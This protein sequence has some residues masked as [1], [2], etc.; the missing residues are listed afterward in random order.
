MKAKKLLALLLTGVMAAAVG[1]FAAAC[2]NGG[3]S[4]GGPAG[5]DEGGGGGT[6]GNYDYTLDETEY[7]LAGKGAGSLKQV[8]EWSATNTTLKLVRD[9][10][11]DHNVF[12]ITIDMYAHDEFKIVHDSD[13]DDNLVFDAIYPYEMLADGYSNG[14][15]Y[16]TGAVSKNEDGEVVFYEGGAYKG[17]ITL[18]SGHDGTYK[19]SL[20][21]YPDGEE[22]T[23]ITW[24]KVGE[25][26]ALS[27]MYVVGDFND[28][29]DNQKQ[30]NKS[31]M[32][33]TGDVWR[34]TLEVTE[35]HLKYNAEG[36]AG[37]DYT[38]IGVMN[39]V[40]DENGVKAVYTSEDYATAIH[41]QDEYNLVPAGKYTVTYNS[42][43]NSV[44]IRALTNDIYFIGSMNGWN[45]DMGEEWKLTEDPTTG[46]W[47]GYLT[48]TEKD[49]A[50]DKV[51]EKDV[52]R[53]YA[54]V[55]LYN[56]LG[57]DNWLAPSEGNLD[58]SGNIML[59]AGDYAFYYN[60]ETKE[61]KYEKL[62]YFVLGTFVDDD[63]HIQ[64]F[65][66]VKDLTPAMTE[67]DGK[68]V[69]TV[70]VTDVSEVVDGTS[71][72]KWLKEQGGATAI[73]AIKVVYGS[74]LL[75]AKDWY[76]IGD[77]GD[78]YFFHAEGEYSVTFDPATKAITVAEVVHEVTVT[79]NL[80]YTDAA[81]P[82]VETITQGTTVTE[83]TEPEREEYTFYG[84]YTE[85]NCENKFDFTKPVNA[86]TELYA[87]WVKT[88]DIPQGTKVTFNFNG[89]GT[90]DKD[91]DIDEYGLV[92]PEAAEWAG[93]Y[94]LGWYTAQN[95]GE[96]VNFN[97][98]VTENKTVYA[99]WRAI[100]THNYHILG[101]LKNYP[102]V[103]WQLENDKTPL[104]HS[105]SHPTEN[106]F[107]ISLRLIVGDK[108]KILG[109][110]TSW[111]D[112]KF[113]AWAIDSSCGNE[114]VYDEPGNDGGNIKV[115]VS[116]DYVLYAS[117]DTWKLTWTVEPFA[118][119]NDMYFV[120]G[121]D[122]TKM[123]AGTDA[124]TGYITVD[125]TKPLKLIDK[126]DGNKEYPVGDGNLP[127]GEY[128][129]KFNV[130][131]KTVQ[132]EKC[133]Y[134]IVGTLVIDDKAVSF[135]IAEGSPKLTGDGNVLT[136]DLT[137]TDI[138]QNA[139]YSWLAEDISKNKLTAGTI[140]A[141]KIGYGSVLGDVRDWYGNYTKNNVVDN[142]S[143]GDNLCFHT[144]G[145]YTVTFDTSTNT[146]TVT[147]KTA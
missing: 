54:T 58:G 64:N 102:T 57:K 124:W 45:T 31:H 108:F 3:G 40:E 35:E 80:N 95:N 78:N 130:E 89:N 97:E 145:E 63:D 10:E 129:V 17:N 1:T 4:G 73:F 106:M 69:A 79:F 86:N 101:E 117:A 62:G 47:S 38:M 74:V 92:A 39:N 18:E 53:D 104:S 142:G 114:L 77:N 132:Y 12:T 137:V 90:P 123:A 59:T 9:E 76:G 91:V 20:H 112:F 19:F 96:L 42:A 94:F 41:E 50:V 105:E 36:E 138:S 65:V 33:K 140:F 56:K 100:D 131:A 24:E 126:Y 60:P 116:G 29:G 134:Y 93:H 85:E 51:D 103:T 122:E 115:A 7:Y 75:G 46:I 55:K 15:S 52:Q 99:H 28:F 141:I 13:Y 107:T 44:S 136:V 81:E 30:F 70:N 84:W 144:A 88:S 8:P 121:E 83:P 48:I 67:S 16:A 128:F 71:N 2:N 82:Q 109:T 23:K 43:D 72:Y 139:G 14:D 37:T 68:Y 127:A 87:R 119:P 11:A 147:Q 26:K 25:L 143:D 118:N 49:Y 133:E 146:I 22:D 27:D 120:Y 21:T 34:Y 111:N 110:T 6:G 125:G 32:T 113:S 135:T 66:I 98:L 5:G 61:I